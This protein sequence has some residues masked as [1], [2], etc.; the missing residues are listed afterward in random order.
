MHT[1]TPRIRYQRDEV[2]SFGAARRLQA[3]AA[4]GWSLPALGEATGVPDNTLRAVR[5][6]KVA[7]TRTAVADAVSAVYD[8]LWDRSPK[9]DT[10]KAL[11][12]KTRTIELADSLGWAKP[13]QWDDE[14]L[15]DPDGQPWVD[16]DF[17]TPCNTC[18]GLG[19]LP[20][21]NWHPPMSLT[22]DTLTLTCR[23]CEGKGKR[24]PV[25][26]R[27]NQIDLGDVEIL[28][29]SGCTWQEAADRLGV[30]RDSLYV[31][32]H[33]V[34]ETRLA[35]LFAINTDTKNADY[36]GLSAYVSTRSALSVAS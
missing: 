15:D 20:G 33:R 4:I 19:R 31:K 17:W 25:R 13:L 23:P 8:R 30:D 24:P 12:W 5:D 28:A 29:T 26:I 1:T 14:D 35:R 34:N 18:G 9:V 22:H 7:L 11:G 6:G 16:E 3:L 10:A 21:R 36:T 2:P 27:A 32:L